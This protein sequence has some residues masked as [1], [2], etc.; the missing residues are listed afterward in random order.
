MGYVP[1]TFM[2]DISSAL[3]ERQAA[4][5]FAPAQLALF[6]LCRS[7]ESEQDR[8]RARQYLQQAAAAG[9][10]RAMWQLGYAYQFGEWGFS[11]DVRAARQWYQRLTETWRQRAR[12]GDADAAGVLALL[13]K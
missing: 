6:R 11:Q 1:V 10:T 8:E 12:E 13:R 3:L 4:E 5:G 7:A 2:G 9:H